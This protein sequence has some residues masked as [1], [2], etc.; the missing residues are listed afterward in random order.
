MAAWMEPPR[1]DEQGATFDFNQY[2]DSEHT[3]RT[4]HYLAEH[5]FPPQESPNEAIL[6]KRRVLPKTARSRSPGN[7]LTKKVSP[8]RRPCNH[9]KDLN[10]DIL[11]VSDEKIKQVSLLRSP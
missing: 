9:E 7:L 1:E 8:E 2:K 5:A 10:R 11:Q 3:S 4:S 6:P